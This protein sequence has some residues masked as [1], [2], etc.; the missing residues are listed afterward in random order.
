MYISIYICEYYVCVINYLIF[1]V[2][3]KKYNLRAKILSYI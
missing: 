3:V 1:N 2:K